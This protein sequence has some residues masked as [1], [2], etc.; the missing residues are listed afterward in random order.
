[1]VKKE[2]TER[3]LYFDIETSMC[4]MY[5]WGLG[6]QYVGYEQIK[7]ERQVICI[8]WKWE[9]EKEVH[10]LSWNHK[11]HKSDAYD[12]DADKVMLMAF[13]KVYNSA[14]LAVGH[15]GLRFDV[16]SI[17]A[18][19]MRYDLPLLDPILFDDTYLK[20]KHIRLNC[21]KLDYLGKYLNVGKKHGTSYT[22][23]I[24]CMNG[25]KKALDEMVKYCAQDVSLL[26]KIYNKVKKYIKSNLN[27]SVIRDDKNICPSCGG[28][29]K[30]NGIKRTATLG[31][32]QTFVCTS[33]GKNSTNGINLIKKANQYPRSM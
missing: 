11:L 5:A 20:T 16:A 17:N 21:H 4:E 32:R 10:A 18:R 15:N 33:C 25:D 30:K 23:W 9:H 12:D 2:P 6:K 31:L 14:D 13:S 29:L 24:N 1:M 27:L 19:L 26:A 8:A 3:I 28:H 22:L 7:K